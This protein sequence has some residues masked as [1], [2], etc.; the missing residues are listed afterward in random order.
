[1]RRAIVAVKLQHVIEVA[2]LQIVA[3]KDPLRIKGH[4]HLPPHVVESSGDRTYPRSG[5]RCSACADG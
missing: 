2:G 3:K 5:A 1:M 4:A